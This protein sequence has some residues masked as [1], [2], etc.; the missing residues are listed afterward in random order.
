MRRSE[1]LKRRFLDLAN[2]LLEPDRFGSGVSVR[3]FETN[4]Y[5]ASDG[6]GNFG[7]NACAEDVLSPMIVNL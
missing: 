6:Q 7:A 3:V 4:I 1:D 5:D 2:T